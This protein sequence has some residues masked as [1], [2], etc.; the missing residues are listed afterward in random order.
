MPNEVIFMNSINNVI[1]NKQR[2]RE[3]KSEKIFVFIVYMTRIPIKILNNIDIMPLKKQISIKNKILEETLS[4]LSGLYQTFIDNLNG[5]N[6]L[7]IDELLHM[8]NADLFQKFVNIDEELRSN[9][10]KVIGYMKYNISVSYKELNQQNYSQTLIELIQNNKRL[11]LLINECFLRNIGDLDLILKAFMD[12]NTFNG[13]EIEIIS[14]IKKYLYSEYISQIS[15]LLY[16]AERDHFFSPLLSHSLTKELFSNKKDMHIIEKAAK[17]YLDDLVYNDGLTRIVEKQGSNKVNITLGLSIPGIKPIFDEIYNNIIENNI[18]EYYR[19]N[20]NNLR[21]IIDIKKIEKEKEK[22]F[23]NL[24][25]YN[26]TLINILNKE[27]KLINILNIINENKEE[28][29]KL[30]DLLIHDYYRFSFFKK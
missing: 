21:Y 3:N 12:E 24:E 30:Y 22:Y 6:K 10:S 20:E 18:L 2:F 14:V 23:E 13:K 9:A 28:K 15:L 27:K 29:S 11:R 16:R 17:A 5:D 25:M 4:N 26:N 1:E 7:N 8:K 19:N